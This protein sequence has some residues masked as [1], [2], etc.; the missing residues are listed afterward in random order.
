MWNAALMK[1]AIVVLNVRQG[2]VRS[3][4]FAAGIIHSAKRFTYKEAF[5]QLRKP[6]ITPIAR[7]LHELNGMAQ[8]LRRRR[9]AKGALDLDFPEVKV[10]VNELGI[11]THLERTE[12]DISHQLIEEFM[13]LANEVVALELKAAKYRPKFTAF[14]ESGYGPG[15]E[16]RAQAK[17][18]GFSCGDLTLAGEIRKLLDRV[19]GRLGRRGEDR[20]AE[21]AEAGDV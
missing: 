1:T 7:Q 6:A 3:F 13:L 17:S 11:P 4:R 12:N 16:F 10:R 18:M 20:T 5:A 19:R 14:H 9:F 21:I 2:E 15:Y 8:T